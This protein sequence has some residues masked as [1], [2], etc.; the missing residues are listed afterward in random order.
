MEQQTDAFAGQQLQQQLEERG[1]QCVTGCGIAAI[2]EH[3][4]V[5]EDGRAFAASRVVLATGVRPNIQ[6]AQRSGLACRRGI[7][8]DHQLATALPGLA[9]LANAAKLTV[10][11][12]DWWR[13]VC[14]RLRCWPGGY[15][16]R[17]RRIFTGR[18]AVPA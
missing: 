17:R 2:R 7:V 18:I 6:L 8:V 4:V 3:D 14:A 5:L 11:P 13:L 16:A 1:I 12:G 10:R 15:A 9:R